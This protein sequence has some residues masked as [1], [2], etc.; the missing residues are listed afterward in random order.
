MALAIDASTPASAAAA[1]NASSV[2]SAAFSP[3]AG[4]V[5]VV[6]LAVDGAGGSTQS[7]SSVTDS[8]GSH[9]SWARITGAQ[10]NTPSAGILGGTAEVWYAS[11]PSAQTGMTVTANFAN[12][13]SGTV[14]P[15]GLILPVVFTGAAT[16]QN[17]AVTKISQTSI[18]TPSLSVT[19]TANGSWVFGVLMNWTNGTGATAG[20]AQTNTINGNSMI[21]TNG[22]DGDAYWVQMQNATTANSG[23]SVTINDTAPTNIRFQFVVVEILA[24]AVAA[25]YL[26]P[27]RYS[28]AVNRAS[29][30]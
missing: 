15:D 25:A 29:T 28:Q 13:G 7:I 30:Y 14:S 24:S 9:L 10:A 17:G 27:R 3:P 12:P 2:V 11:C 8:L 18:S 23:T 22:T 5:I 1:G 26:P 16:T 21:R 4:S 6:F 19:T 20:T